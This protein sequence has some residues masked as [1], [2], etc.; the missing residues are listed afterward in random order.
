M[1]PLYNALLN[2]P[3]LYQG[4]S[5]LVFNAEAVVAGEFSQQV[6]LPVNQA[7]G[8]KGVRVVID[9][10]ANP[11][12]CEYQICEA[13]N[14]GAGSSDYVQVPNGGDLTQGTITSGPNGLLT[15]LTSDLIPVAGQNLV[16]FVKTPPS[17]AGIKVTARITRAV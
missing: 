9:H 5:S 11:G 12:N 4:D 13:D 7:S 10:S 2:A 14:D 6:A 17:N 15:R 8:T 16:L 1:S 3:A